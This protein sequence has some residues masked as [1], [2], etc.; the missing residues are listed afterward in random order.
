MT[1][2]GLKIYGHD[3]GAAVITSDGKVVAIAEERLNR[4]KHS[5][6]IFPF[7][8]IDYCLR[9]QG[10]PDDAVDLVVIDQIYEAENLPM[11]KMFRDSVGSRFSR[12]RVEVVNHHDAHA[13]SAFF[14]SPFLRAAVVVYDGSGETFKT[15][16]GIP[17]TETETLYLGDG[18]GIRELQKT[19]HARFAKRFL[20]TFGV[21]MLYTA[22]TH[23]LSFGAYE[24]GKTMG[25]APYG[26]PDLLK[27]FPYARWFREWHGHFYCN[28]KIKS[29]GG[30]VSGS[31]PE[32]GWVRK[33]YYGIRGRIRSLVLAFAQRLLRKD[34]FVD[35]QLFDPLV[36]PEPARPKSVKL[37]D[38]YYTN[39]AYAV[40]D[41]L[42]QV[43]IG[44]AHRAKELTQADY[45]V[46]AGG[47][48][49]N[50]VA[51]KKILDQCGYK[52]IWIQPACSDTGIALGC[53]LYGWHVT[54]K[55]PR[56]WVMKNAYLG[57]EYSVEE[58]RTAIEREQNNLIIEQVPNI[59][60]RTAS[61]LADGKIIGWFQGRSEYGPRALG[62]RSIIVDPRNPNMK[63]ILNNRVKHREGWRPFA[64]SVLEE[65]ASEYF[66]LDRPSPY[67]LLVC[68]VPKHLQDKITAVVHVDGTCRVQTVNKADN[69]IYYDLI[70]SFADK[71]G[72]PMI[73]NTS[74]NLAGEPIIESPADAV[75]CFLRTDMDYLVVG[76]YLLRKK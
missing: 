71:T 32:V 72:M 38:T 45:L 31:D 19:M 6:N 9:A 76:N 13:A 53:A 14:C 67:M 37:P 35:P 52:D 44:W 40:Q 29:S 74:F 22:I 47:V 62:N 34:F 2:L 39:V 75:S 4:N 56:Q 63:D 46:I 58:Q 28:A 25:L 48:G 33:G 17:A 57:R 43:V 61:L 49:L 26:K 60:L 21:G 69:G 8:S 30:G 51:N 1:V 7:L 55:Q 65:R 5:T 54:L 42:E 36:L 12:A 23:Y 18:A 64:A 3:T 50:S 24:E 66:T 15:P 20:H 41:V 59:A 10:V 70:K 11:A 73:L 27:D 16:L 68:D